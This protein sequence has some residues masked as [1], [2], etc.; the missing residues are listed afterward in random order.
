MKHSASNN[1]FAIAAPATASIEIAGQQARFPVRRIYCLVRN[2]R[3]H[4]IESGDDPDQVPP[5]FFMKPGDTIVADRGDFPYP[6]R[7]TRV[8]YEIEMVVAISGGGS[9]I[10]ADHA[11]QHVYGYAVGLDMTRRDLQ[12][13]AKKLSRPWEGAKSFDHSAPCGPLHRVADIGHPQSGR[14]WLSVN[15]E[16]KQESDISLMRWSVAESIAVLSS[17]FELA[18]GDLVYTGTPAGIGPVVVGD[19]I[20]G[21]VD[22]IDSIAV[23]VV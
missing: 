4:A 5:F 22:G 16:V 3:D 13:E 10:A 7:S 14:I 21:G 23:R 9:S 1:D 11:L 20:R 12:D 18:P 19:I 8:D 15:D 6:V 2:Y 17:Y